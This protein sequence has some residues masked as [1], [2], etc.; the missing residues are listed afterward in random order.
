[1]NKEKQAKKLTLEEGG[2]EWYK[3]IIMEQ[4]NEVDNAIEV[5]PSSTPQW[6]AVRNKTLETTAHYGTLFAQSFVAHIIPSILVC[7]T[8]IVLSLIIC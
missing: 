2:P 5:P 3:R 1:M 6:D 8:L 7:L 4:A